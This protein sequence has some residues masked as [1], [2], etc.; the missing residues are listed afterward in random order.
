MK[1]E[2]RSQEN[3]T[4][5][6]HRQEMDAH[7]RETG[8]SLV[9]VNSGGDWEGFC[10]DCSLAYIFGS[11]PEAA[12]ED[13]LQ[14]TRLLHQCCAAVITDFNLERVAQAVYLHAERS[15]NA[16]LGREI[17]TEVFNLIDVIE[18]DTDFL[19][20]ATSLE[21]L[22]WESCTS[23]LQRCSRTPATALSYWSAEMWCRA[24]TRHMKRLA[25]VPDYEEQYA[26][27]TKLADLWPQALTA[28]CRVTPSLHASRDNA[29]AAALLKMEFTH[30]MVAHLQSAGSCSIS[31]ISSKPDELTQDMTSLVGFIADEVT[32]ESVA[33]PPVAQ[34]TISM[35]STLSEHK[36]HLF[37]LLAGLLQI[38]GYKKQIVDVALQ[39]SYTVTS[40][41]RLEL[42]PAL[43]LA[44]LH[45]YGDHSGSDRCAGLHCILTLL[46]AA[47][48]TV[49]TGTDTKTAGEQL[50][51]LTQ[52]LLADDCHYSS[53]L[54]GIWDSAQSSGNV[55]SQLH[56]VV[57]QTFEKLALGCPER[58][59]HY[60]AFPGKMCT[61]LLQ[62]YVVLVRQL[63]QSRTHIA[64]PV[65]GGSGQDHGEVE[66]KAVQ[67]VLQQ[68]LVRG[69]CG[70]NAKN[71]IL[72]QCS[73]ILDTAATEGTKG[74]YLSRPEIT[75][76][77]A[78]VCAVAHVLPLL[79][80]ML[81]DNCHN[82]VGVVLHAVQLL[83]QAL[84]EPSPGVGSAM[85]EERYCA[86]LLCRQCLNTVK[87][88][89]LLDTGFDQESA[90]LS[91]CAT[92][93]SAACTLLSTDCRF[94]CTNHDE[95]FLALLALLVPRAEQESGVDLQSLYSTAY[96]CRSL[97]S[98]LIN[99]LLTET[100]S[101]QVST[102]QDHVDNSPLHA[103]ARFLVYCCQ[104]CFCDTVV[105]ADLQKLVNALRSAL[106]RHNGCA[107]S[108]PTSSANDGVTLTTL[109]SLVVTICSDQ[110]PFPISAEVCASGRINTVLEA[111]LDALVLSLA[112]DPVAVC[113]AAPDLVR[114]LLHLITTVDVTPTAATAA[115]RFTY[116]LIITELHVL[117]ATG[118][119]AV[120][121][122]KVSPTHV[123]QRAVSQNI[124]VEVTAP[125]LC[126]YWL[127]CD[128]G[129]AR[130]MLQRL[131]QYAGS[132]VI[133]TLDAD[134]SAH[135]SRLALQVVRELSCSAF[136][137][138]VPTLS[139]VAAQLV[140]SG[141]H[142]T[143]HDAIVTLWCAVLEAISNEGICSS[144]EN[145][146]QHSESTVP[147]TQTT[148]TAPDAL[149]TLAQALVAKHDSVLEIL[150]S[151]TAFTQA[152]SSSKLS[153][154]VQDTTMLLF[155]TAV[156][157]FT[158]TGSAGLAKLEEV[159][160]F[161]QRSGW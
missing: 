79:Q 41:S 37:T 78:W 82:V 71:V 68:A 48:T 124:A 125:V 97:H 67:Y 45:L 95:L 148:I 86:V 39:P 123:Q 14:A 94:G 145:L 110:Q 152:R 143:K 122:R 57:A 92:L 20:D 2:A 100:T 96:T 5:K 42:A 150:R 62:R 33:A 99:Y 27:S 85:Y 10:F 114:Q 55:S 56:S 28:Y 24:A 159:A 1:H 135:I 51:Q 104:C 151:A 72:A 75:S 7:T 54:F 128:P 40:T 149:G 11:G 9:V 44:A 157:A 25:F 105:G 73:A 53:R 155:P 70:S 46:Q 21:K 15:L 153:K 106:Y 137:G 16:H 116:Q 30:M 102:G 50:Q 90:L 36:E 31:S 17:P 89:G 154:R 87:Q 84:T 118:A 130:H 119:Q 111:A 121:P 142:T 19:L 134:S 23:A 103:Y 127:S 93:V 115:V 12:Y 144:W 34:Q 136:R 101:R 26:R 80:Q 141:V 49:V 8:H 66:I 138:V 83:A 60:A 131:L 112:P 38:P 32:T 76:S 77:A 61:T 43:A 6:Y 63:V 74:A 126:E 132:L 108:A 91:A 3:L 64:L 107:G 69:A 129:L 156:A 88:H 146:Q 58:F 98:A 18:N 120:L 81:H 35:T 117:D 52:Q 139:S 47:T 133:S 158:G 65:L 113:S 4:A 109:C 13:R 59:Y 22:A 29:H 161:A 140:A 147:G 160:E